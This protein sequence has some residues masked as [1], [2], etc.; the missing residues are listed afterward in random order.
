MYNKKNVIKHIPTFQMFSGCQARAALSK[1]DSSLKFA[2]TKHSFKKPSQVGWIS[3]A[4]VRS[5]FMITT[6]TAWAREESQ[7]PPQGRLRTPPVGFELET[8]CFQFYAIANLDKT[9]LFQN[10]DHLSRF[11]FAS[12][13]V[14][15]QF[16]G[17]FNFRSSWFDILALIST[18]PCLGS[19]LGHSGLLPG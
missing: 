12:D 18:S 15:G 4:E 7:V 3:R 9:S 19:H 2:V 1:S 5:S 6:T 13:A 17:R 10:T 16:T 14:P 8:N 11:K